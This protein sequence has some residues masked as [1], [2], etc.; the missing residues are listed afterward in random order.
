[1]KLS[2]FRD[3]VASFQWLGS[4]FSFGILGKVAKNYEKD[5]CEAVLNFFGIIGSQ[6]GFI[7]SVFFVSVFILTLCKQDKAKIAKNAVITTTVICLA[8][9][10]F[11]IIDFIIRKSDLNHEN[12]G[13]SEKEKIKIATQE[14]CKDVLCIQAILSLG[15]SI[16]DG[17]LQIVIHDCFSKKKYE[18]FSPIVEQ[19]SNI[20]SQDKN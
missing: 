16:I 1:M 9:I 13:K 7:F 18:L 5:N 17:F 4:S 14:T 15:G 20:T 6:S 10:T 12:S 3:K 19:V 11:A 2:E 8:I